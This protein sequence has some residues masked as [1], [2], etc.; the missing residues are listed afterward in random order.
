MNVNPFS[1][2]TKRNC[3]RVLHS[4]HTVCTE[5]HAYRNLLLILLRVNFLGEAM[6]CI[7]CDQNKRCCWKKQI[8]QFKMEKVFKFARKWRLT[9]IFL[10]F[11]SAI[12]NNQC[13]PESVARVLLDSYLWHTWTCGVKGLRN[14]FNYWTCMHRFSGKWDFSTYI[15]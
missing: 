13:M 1:F 7:H 3:Q 11:H 8:K 5:Q 6:S 10:V 14:R 12:H 9:G 15:E 4:A 2:R